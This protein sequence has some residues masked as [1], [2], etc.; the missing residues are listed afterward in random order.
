[1]KDERKR[2]DGAGL[3]GQMRKRRANAIGPRARPGWNCWSV[4]IVQAEGCAWNGLRQ[5]KSCA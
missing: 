5:A 1:M 4:V 3:W 2:G